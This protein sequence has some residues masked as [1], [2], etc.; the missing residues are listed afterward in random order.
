MSSVPPSLVAI[1]HDDYHAAYVGRTDDGQQF[2]LTT[3]FEPA[4]GDSPGREF[5]ALFVFD[6]S[7]ALVNAQI[8]DLGPRATIDHA[9]RNEIRDRCEPFDSGQ[10]DT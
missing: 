9:K 1:D 8:E 3:P 2:F 7:G 6:T 10:C 4:R 5:I